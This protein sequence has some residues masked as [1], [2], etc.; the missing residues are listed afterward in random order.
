MN[1]PDLQ[2][3]LIQADTDMGASETHG[4]LNGLLCTANKVTLEIWMQLVLE[5]SEPDNAQIQSIKVLLTTLYNETL[6][7]FKEDLFTITPLLPDDNTPLAHR[8]EMLVLWSNGFLYGLGLG[9]INFKK[10]SKESKDA[11]SSL[12]DLTKIDLDQ[13]AED[14]ESEQAFFELFEF[15]K[16][17]T[18][19]IKEELLSA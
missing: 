3:P 8:L 13:I 4:I 10:L 12:T 9:Q 7:A 1:Y 2:Q 16:L 6:T 11:I 19:L 15:S 18:T 14:E 17:A 5:N